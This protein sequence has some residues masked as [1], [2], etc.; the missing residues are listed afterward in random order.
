MMGVRGSASRD[1]EPR[2][3]VSV[4]RL[5]PELFHWLSLQGRFGICFIFRVMAI[6]RVTDSFFLNNFTF[7]IA[8]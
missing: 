3:L 7:R 8:S 1:R 2:T 4:P 6:P 5:Q